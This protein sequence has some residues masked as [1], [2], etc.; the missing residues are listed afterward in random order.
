MMRSDLPVKG[1]SGS[2]RTNIQESEILEGWFFGYGKDEFCCFEGT[3]NDMVCFARNVLA[4][5]NTK[6]VS[7]EYYHPEYAN[8]NY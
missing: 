8:D 7:P 6:I 5:E 1:V 3:W 2:K 4:S